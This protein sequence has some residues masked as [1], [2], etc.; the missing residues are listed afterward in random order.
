MNIAEN[1]QLLAT[2]K[3]NIRLAINQMG[4]S[5]E[6]TTPFSAYTAG[7][8][9]IVS[10]FAER[11]TTDI[12][13]PPGTSGI[14]DYAFY[15]Y[16]TLRSVNIPDS[17]T[18]IGNRAFMNCSGL[19][20]VS[21]GNG[22]QSIGERA[23]LACEM[24]QVAEIPDSVTTIG[25]FCFSGCTRMSGLTIGDS[26]QTISSNAFTDCQRLSSVTIADSVQTIG[27]SAFNNCSRLADVTI[28]SGVTSIGSSAFNGCDTHLSVTC[29]A[30]T[31]PTLGNT[32]FG[33]TLNYLTIYVPA[34]SLQDYKTEWST[35]SSKIIAI[36]TPTVNSA[37][38]DSNGNLMDECD[39]ATLN[40]SSFIWLTPTDSFNVYKLVV[41]S[42]VTLIDDFP[43]FDSFANLKVVD[44]S[45]AT[46]LT[47]IGANAFS[48]PFNDTLTSDDTPGAPNV[49]VLPEGL[50][51]IGDGAFDSLSIT[52]IDIPST[53][54]YLGDSSV[55]VQGAIAIRTASPPSESGYAFR[56]SGEFTMYV[57]DASVTNYE[58]FYP[59]AQ[60]GAIMPLSQLVW[61]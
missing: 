52:N 44:F 18:T 9:S 14:S 33:T 57:P 43:G 42:N 6:T 51:T 39:V 31:P 32:V 61:Q 22:V 25:T 24:L 11:K 45:N 50:T 21:F 20:S 56:G 55:V 17:V 53:I 60:P 41:G 30:T 16:T 29:L 49:V 4:G 38:Y 12:E 47:D 27:A 46:S 1:L 59:Y 36:P 58:A 13:I 15:N 37:L 26:V 5:V 40:M 54:Q 19:T 2:T 8:N 35:Y 7:I 34:A 23:F 3:D 48:G 10:G 28:G